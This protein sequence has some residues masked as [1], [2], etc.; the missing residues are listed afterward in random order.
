M[1]PQIIACSTK[2]MFIRLKAF[3][4]TVLSWGLIDFVGAYK[5][6]DEYRNGIDQIKWTLDYFVKCHVAPEKFYHQVGD[7][8]LDHAWWGRPEDMTMSRP[9]NV[10]T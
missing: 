9:A 4:T 10:R 7:G 5:D 2:S 3:A 8:A 6:A 1:T